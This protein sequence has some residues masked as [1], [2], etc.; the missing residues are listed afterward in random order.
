MSPSGR[1]FSGFAALLAFTAACSP[2][3]SAGRLPHASIDSE[4]VEATIAADEG[5]VS[6][7]PVDPVATPEPAPA[8]KPRPPVA[9]KP[10]YVPPSSGPY[11]LRLVDESHH[12]LPRFFKEGRAYVMGKVGTRYSI[13]VSNRSSRRVEVVLSVDGLDAMDGE[14]ANYAAKRGYILAPYATETIDGFRT[15]VEDVATFRFSSVADSY[16]GRLG[17]ARDVGVIGAAFFPEQAPVPTWE[18][19]PPSATETS[20]ARPL[21]SPP[22]RSAPPSGGA[23]PG[24]APAPSHASRASNDFGPAD[25][26]QAAPAQRPGLGTEFGEARSSH[27][28]FTAFERENA[29][30]PRLVL[31]IRY[32]DRAGLV[33]LGIPIPPP[34]AVATT[35]QQLRETADP[36]RTNHFAQPPP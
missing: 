31:S 4:A 2:S 19:P 12:D 14:P 3:S 6:C 32:N 30:H 35:D 21:P 11:T 1:T 8:P 13:V 15:S 29:S 28:D 22:R 26:A 23:G 7:A 33:A 9:S 27:L 17:E 36:F 18:P 20:R 25:E 10:I 34:Y 5:P 24:A 16:A